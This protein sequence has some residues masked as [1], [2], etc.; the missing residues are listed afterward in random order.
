MGHVKTVIVLSGGCLL[1][2]E[3]MPVK[4]F[5]GVC[6][7]MS[8]IVWYSFLKMKVCCPVHLCEGG[9]VLY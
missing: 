2:G 9:D 3:A 6:L 5:M 8:G 1:F 4:R 7:A